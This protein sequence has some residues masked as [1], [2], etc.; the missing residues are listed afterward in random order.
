VYRPLPAHTIASLLWS[1]LHGIAALKLS[2]SEYPFEGGIAEPGET[3]MDILER[4][5]LA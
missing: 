2:C 3:L 1:S 5:L 4:G